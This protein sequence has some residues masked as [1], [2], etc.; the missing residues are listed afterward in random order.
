MRKNKLMN[1][2]KKTVSNYDSRPILK[3]VNYN[4]NGN[5]YATDSHVGLK[6]EDFH[7]LKEDLNIDVFTMKINDSKFPEIENL[8]SID[9]PTA[10]LTVNIQ[11]LIKAIKPFVEKA[12]PDEVVTLKTE[13]KELIISS[14]SSF[15]K[16][17][18]T[19]VAINDIEGD[20]EISLV[21][22][23]LLNGLEFIRDAK[24]DLK[25]N[26]GLVQIQFQSPV[27]PFKLLSNKGH[28]YLVTPVRQ[29]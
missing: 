26:D 4:K 29:F 2:L 13:N 18:K 12:F 24:Q 11:M 25:P 27:R 19:N 15:L 14:R 6:V 1:H 5:L 17:L 20:V 3:C 8:F 21:P 7:E 22:S 23:R 9:K 28:E 10:E 16:D